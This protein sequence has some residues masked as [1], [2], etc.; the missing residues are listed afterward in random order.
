MTEIEELQAQIDELEESSPL[1]NITGADIDKNAYLVQIFDKE[2]KQAELSGWVEGFS[3]TSDKAGLK[4]K[5][6]PLDMAEIFAD[7][8]TDICVVTEVN[9]FNEGFESRLESHNAEFDRLTVEME[10]LKGNRI[11]LASLQAFRE[12]NKDWKHVHYST[13]AYFSADGK[14]FTID[15]GIVQINVKDRP[16]IGR[17]KED[18]AFNELTEEISRFFESEEQQ[19]GFIEQLK[20]TRAEM[21]HSP[22]H[23]VIE[24]GEYLLYS[25]GYFSIQL[26]LARFLYALQNKAE[27][28][29]I[30]PGKKNFVMPKTPQFNAFKEPLTEDMKV[31]TEGT[32][33]ENKDVFK[34]LT[35]ATVNGEQIEAELLTIQPR[36]IMQLNTKNDKNLRT[37][38]QDTLL[39]LAAVCTIIAPVPAHQFPVIVPD[40]SVNDQL[41]FKT[42]SESRKKRLNQNYDTMKE[43]SYFYD[44]EEEAKA[45]QRLQRKLKSEELTDF[46]GKPI[47]GMKE[48]ESFINSDP[49]ICFDEFGNTLHCHIIYTKPYFLIHT[50]ATG[51]AATI[52]RRFI[53]I[54]SLPSISR[55][56][57]KIVME[58]GAKITDELYYLNFYHLESKNFR[59]NL[60]SFCNNLEIPLNNRQSKSTVLRQITA[61]LYEYQQ[62][63]LIAKFKEVKAGRRITSIEITIAKENF[64]RV[65]NS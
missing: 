61:L 54:T 25:Q 19:Q 18:E 56:I 10:F 60:S 13:K 53:D 26:K 51:Q 42:F 14:T 63:G 39:D 3:F 49:Y 59:I 34:H 7:P 23:L 1:A 20:K 48:K 37:L 17:G 9:T 29:L 16:K 8:N 27:I 43:K 22:A 62:K 36:G 38:E 30:R 15:G 47:Y 24:T 58:L 6:K 31:N 45:R 2:G 32:N 11:E 52:D 21:L 44:W 28:N 46:Y 12:R 4:D 35:V 41:P 64:R 5:S 40:K 50:R 57:E 65:H 55:N 33:F